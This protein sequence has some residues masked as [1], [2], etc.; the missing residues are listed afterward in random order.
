M[1]TLLF[2]SF[3][4][5]FA[6]LYRWLLPARWRGTALLVG[7]IAALYWLAPPSHIRYLDFLLPTLTIV[8][9]IG[10]WWYTRTEITLAREDR[11]TLGL[12]GLLIVAVALL[13]SVAPGLRPE[14]SAAPDPVSAGIGLIVLAGVV[15]A[16]VRIGINRSWLLAGGSAF[17]ILLFVVLKTEPL[18]TAVSGE[19]HRLTGTR[20]A[21]GQAGDL[22]WLG[23]SY[24]AFRWLHMLR[25]RQSGRLPAL[26]LQE[27]LTYVLFFPALIAGPIDRAER[28]V[29]DYRALPEE[30]IDAVR[31]MS[32]A[33]RIILGVLKKFVIADSLAL[34]SLG[35]LTAGQV[36]TPLAA[37]ALLYLYGFRLLF[38]FSGYTD[39]AIG[40]GQLLGIKLPEN[41]DRPYFKTN[42]ASFW[43]SWHMT[44]SNWVRFYVYFP[45]SRLLLKSKV[46][47]PLWCIV[48]VAQVITMLVIGLWH[49]VTWS[50]A[51]WG[52]WHGVGLFVHKIWSDR[53][54]RVYLRLPERPRVRLI[55]SLGGWFL[56][57]QF[58]ML[59]WVWFVLPDLRQGIEIFLKLFGIGW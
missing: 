14:L 38:D 57:F 49:G 3:S 18:V 34:V 41:F 50:F 31:W 46:R 42:L 4:V 19:L 27:T 28:F 15:L 16:P 8:F 44:L 9:S 36:T 21:A 1:V 20:P 26:A 17:F 52:L 11:T 40:T 47:L 29:A 55:W 22:A 5:I 45:L 25:D 43:Q 12:V 59:G 48:L 23:F 58:V 30:R 39:I 37:W 33:N 35:P 53:T 24:M 2:I 10:V 13:R 51:M 7:S 6:F 54:R 32:P 56:T